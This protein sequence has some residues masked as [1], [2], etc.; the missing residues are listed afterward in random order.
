[1]DVGSGSTIRR[2]ADV[3]ACKVGELINAKVQ[4]ELMGK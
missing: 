2:R 1:M 4:G 3:H